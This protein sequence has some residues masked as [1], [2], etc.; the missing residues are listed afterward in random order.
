MCSLTTGPK[1]ITLSSYS[2]KPWTIISLSYLEIDY[3]GIYY[4]KGTL[5]ST[6]PQH[7]KNVFIMLNSSHLISCLSINSTNIVFKVTL[8]LVPAFREKYSIP[9][10]VTSIMLETHREE[11]G[12]LDNLTFSVQSQSLGG[13]A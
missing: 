10:T 12:R 11:E 1:A 8:C 5:S 6:N 4:R 3:S 7:A 2:A 13:E 9:A